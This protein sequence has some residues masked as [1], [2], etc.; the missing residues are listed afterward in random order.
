MKFGLAVF[1][2]I[3]SITWSC[4]ESTN[5]EKVRNEVSA[6]LDTITDVDSTEQAKPVAIT[7][8]ITCP[9]CGNTSEEVMPTEVCQL[10]YTCKNCKTEMHPQG[11]DCCVFCSYGDHKCPS[12]QL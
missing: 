6:T 5:A 9:T 1:V 12:K 3:L 7:S 10:A 2:L 11:D 4:S 8:K